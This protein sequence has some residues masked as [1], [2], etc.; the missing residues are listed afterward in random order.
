MIYDRYYVMDVE[1]LLKVKK[2]WKNSNGHY[3][4]RKMLIL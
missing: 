3:V 2:M 4:L 1:E